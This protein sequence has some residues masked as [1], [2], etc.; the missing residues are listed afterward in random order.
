MTGSEGMKHTQRMLASGAKVV[1]GVNPR[2]AGQ[3]V[4]FDGTVAAGLRHRGRGDGRDRRR[5]SRS[6]SCRRPFTK[7]AV[8]EAIDAEIP[9]AV[10]ITEGVPV[11]DIDRVLGA[12]R[13]A[14]RPASSARTAPA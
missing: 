14:S 4:D 11:H 6:S 2:K 3:K 9:L 7:D 8:I 10:V 1:G 12:T 13:R 5:T